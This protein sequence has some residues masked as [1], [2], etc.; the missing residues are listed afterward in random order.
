MNIIF[1]K[2]HQGHKNRPVNT[3][4]LITIEMQANMRLYSNTEF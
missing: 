2:R 4:Q 1:F 3:T